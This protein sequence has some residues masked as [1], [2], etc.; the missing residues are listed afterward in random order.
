MFIFFLSTNS[1]FTKLSGYIDTNISLRL[2]ANY[3]VR[4]ID[5][6]HE[7]C[8]VLGRVFHTPSPSSESKKEGKISNRYNQAPHLTQ[9]ANGKVT[10]S[11]LDITND[12][13]E[14]SSF[15]EGDHKVY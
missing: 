5:N 15:P 12:S 2:E 10:T 7:G 14:V 8:V 11:Q 13:E 6:F 1:I 3:P 9:D 4:L